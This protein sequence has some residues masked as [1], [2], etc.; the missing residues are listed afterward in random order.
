MIKFEQNLKYSIS[1]L[2]SIIKRKT[3][4]SLGKTIRISGDSILKILH[5]KILNINDLTSIAKKFFRNRMVYIII[6][7]SLIDKLYSTCIEGTSDNFSSAD[8]RIYRSLSTV[9][10]GLT[11]GHTFIPIN[12]QIWTA[13]EFNEQYYKKKWAIAHELIAEIR[14]FIPIHFVIA[15]GTICDRKYDA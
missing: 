8:N 3:C 6:D 2:L 4:E 11:D 10:A 9:V 13:K 7:D 15:D 1:L 14:Q 5:N 12:Q